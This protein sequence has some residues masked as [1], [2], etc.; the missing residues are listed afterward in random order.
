[1][2][3]LKLA[4]DWNI[5]DMLVTLETSQDEIS[6]LNEEACMKSIS[7]FVKPRKFHA[8]RSWL[9]DSATAKKFRMLPHV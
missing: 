8:D 5:W 3:W 4:A 9:K 7:M 1:M 6:P 2:S